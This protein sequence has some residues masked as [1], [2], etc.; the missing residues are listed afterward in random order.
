MAH[1]LG[2]W[3]SVKVS[4]TCFRQCWFLNISSKSSGNQLAYKNVA[5]LIIINSYLS[6]YGAWGSV[7]V[8]A[9]RC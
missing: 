2:G 1:M 7:V 4:Q 5:N 6:F 3:L 9:L 8:K